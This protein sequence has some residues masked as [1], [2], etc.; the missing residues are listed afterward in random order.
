[1]P[2]IRNII[3]HDEGGLW[4]IDSSCKICFPGIKTSSEIAWVVS[5]MHYGEVGELKKE[6]PTQKSVYSKGG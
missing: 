3:I 6:N 2:Q 1:M 4:C 5:I